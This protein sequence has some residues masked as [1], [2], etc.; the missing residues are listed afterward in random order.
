VLDPILRNGLG[1]QDSKQVSEPERKLPPLYDEI[2]HIADSLE[3]S[4]RVIEE[5]LD[6]VEL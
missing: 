3:Y 6:R 5:T 1:A 4:L 2:K